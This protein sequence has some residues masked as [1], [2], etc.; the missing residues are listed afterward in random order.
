MIFP[1]NLSKPWRFLAWVLSYFL[2]LEFFCHWIFSNG[3]RE[4]SLCKYSLNFL[5]IM[6]VSVFVRS[7]PFVHLRIHR[8]GVRVLY[9]GKDVVADYLRLR[10]AGYR[11]IL[12]AA[13]LMFQ[14]DGWCQG[15]WW[16]ATSWVSLESNS[17]FFYLFWQLLFLFE[18]FLSIKNCFYFDKWLLI[19]PCI[20]PISSIK[21]M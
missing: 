11:G 19:G 9:S 5:Q 7:K 13:R 17:I 2:A 20:S 1:K 8:L 10:R 3:P 4:P 6:L 12:L 21:S 18:Y 16:R 14:A 15:F